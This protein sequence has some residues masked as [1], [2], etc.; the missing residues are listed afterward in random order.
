MKIE[1][2][3]DMSANDYQQENS[4]LASSCIKLQQKSREVKYE[5]E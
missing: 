2:D 4:S 3:T 1:S 5:T